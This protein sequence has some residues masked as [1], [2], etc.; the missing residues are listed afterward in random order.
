LSLAF[1]EQQLAL[2][3]PTRSR[4]R[5]GIHRM[6]QN[7]YKRL[8]ELERVRAADL[9]ASADRAAAQLVVEGFQAMM[10]QYAIEPLPSESRAYAFARVLGISS[11]E[12]ADLLRKRSNEAD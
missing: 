11:R 12:L 2:P 1:I 10:R 8:E 4:G 6:K 5:Y 3:D 9:Q 7:I